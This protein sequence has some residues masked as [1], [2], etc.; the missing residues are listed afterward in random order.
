MLRTGVTDNA[1]NSSSISV[2]EW[3]GV[4]FLDKAS[5][6]NGYAS[7]A[8]GFACKQVFGPERGLWPCNVFQ[9]PLQLFRISFCVLSCALGNSH[10][11]GGLQ[12]PQDLVVYPVTSAG[13]GQRSGAVRLLTGLLLPMLALISCL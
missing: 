5:D 8:Q 13:W 1:A 4:G 10:S 9:S 7:T 3:Q 11:R 2:P 12:Y 6:V